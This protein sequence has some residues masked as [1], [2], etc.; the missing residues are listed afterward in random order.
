MSTLQTHTTAA[1][2]LSRT[3]LLIAAVVALVVAA[4]AVVVTWGGD[5]SEPTPVEFRLPSHARIHG[6]AA[7][8]D[9]SVAP[10]A[11]GIRHDGGPEEGTRGPTGLMLTA[12]AAVAAQDLRSPDTRD[13]AA[14]SQM[15][16]DLRSPDSRDPI[17]R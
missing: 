2:R 12:P 8:P 9:I 5:G 13:G 11:N 14:A 7:V 16:Q 17:G 3:T 6:G 15:M 10:L 1:P 4:G